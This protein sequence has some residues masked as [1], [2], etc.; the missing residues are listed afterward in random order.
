MSYGAGTHTEWRVTGDPGPGFPPYDVVLTSEEKVRELLDIQREF[1]R[2]VK[3]VQV[4]RRTVTI[5]EWEP[6][7]P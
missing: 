4:R 6:N 2:N 5:T 3:D 7:A 1:V